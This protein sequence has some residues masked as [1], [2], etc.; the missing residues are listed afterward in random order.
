MKVLSID[1]DEVIT[2]GG[3]LYAINTFLRTNY[4]KEDFKD[5]YMQDVVPKE[6]QEDCFKFLININIYKHCYFLDGAVDTI[7]LLNEKYD[8]VINTSY[9]IREIPY[10]SGKLLLQK[11]NFFMENLPF[12]SPNQFIFGTRKDLV[13]ADIK[14]DD[15]LDN[16]KNCKTKYL[17]TNYHNT[18]LT[19]EDLNKLDVVRVNDWYDVKAKLLVK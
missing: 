11:H 8:L 15:R 3:F 13:S 12:L 17:F 18:N 5:F 1:Q 7:R 6:L 14:I 9:I 10:L 2:E 19:Y 16:L 4:V